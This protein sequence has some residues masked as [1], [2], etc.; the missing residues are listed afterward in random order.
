MATVHADSPLQACSRLEV[1][2]LMAELG[3]PIEAL[4]RQIAEALNIVVQTSRLYDGRRCITDISEISLDYS[5]G[6]Y[7]ITDIFKLRSQNTG[8]FEIEWT[9]KKLEMMD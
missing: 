1:M 7:K 2:A 5:T 3:L 4:R 9:G 8:E 6:M